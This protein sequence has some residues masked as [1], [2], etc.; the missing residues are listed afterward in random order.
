[1]N[2]YTRPDRTAPDYRRVSPG[3]AYHRWHVYDGTDLKTAETGLGFLHEVGARID[4]VAAMREFRAWHGRYLQALE[5]LSAETDFVAPTL[6]RLVAGTAT[7]P[8]LETGLHIHPLW[9]VP[10]LPGSSIRGLLH[11][12]AED[13]AVA[14]AEE[15][16]GAALQPSDAPPAAVQVLLRRC[17]EVRQVFGGIT[18][19]RG[20]TGK[21]STQLVG[22]ETPRNLLQAWTD[23]KLLEEPEHGH[24][25]SLLQDPTSGRLAVYD[26]FPEPG[27]ALVEADVLNPHYPD[28]YGEHD[29]KPPSDD[30][31]PKPVFFLAVRAGVRF[32]FP[33]RLCPRSSEKAGNAPL[34]DAEIRKLV[35]SWL[36]EALETWGAGAKTAAGY[37]YFVTPEGELSSLMEAP[38]A[39]PG[40]A[41]ATGPRPSDPELQVWPDAY[42]TW[43]A[44]TSR[45]EAQFD[46]REAHGGREALDTLPEEVRNRLTGG[47][48]E[49]GKKRKKGKPARYPIEVRALGETHFEIVRGLPPEDETD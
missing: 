41:E 12:Y 31:N 20:R 46:G 25:R 34:S 16:A 21:G 35:T 32:R 22:S 11:H 1:M 8:A 17:R 39:A 47:P 24:A 48:K 36:N 38:R 13:Q 6:W 37:G 3:L 33:W 19:E 2:L 26:A 15:E 49:K 23:G 10:Y 28:Y 18:V 5:R 44:N 30:Q 7:N 42:L 43:Q 27:Q 40:P 14:A 45:L 4:A 9:G 29:R